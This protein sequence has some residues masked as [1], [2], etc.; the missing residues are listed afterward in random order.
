V[1]W[2]HVK[3]TECGWDSGRLTEDEAGKFMKGSGGICLQCKED[4]KKVEFRVREIH[5][6]TLK[7]F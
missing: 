4:G 5:T 6:S 2:I 1:K 3:C 7:G